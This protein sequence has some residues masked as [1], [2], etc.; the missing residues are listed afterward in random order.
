MFFNPQ[1]LSYIVCYKNHGAVPKIHCQINHKKYIPIM[2]LSVLIIPLSNWLSTYVEPHNQ[3]SV[4]KT[5]VKS[6]SRLTSFF[7]SYWLVM[8]TSCPDKTY[9]IRYT[10]NT[11]YIWIESLSEPKANGNWGF[12]HKVDR[13]SLTQRCHHSAER[14]VPIATK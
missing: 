14:A 2:N 10:L 1:Y 11:R 9:T 8:S 6:F 7:C 5:V 4:L 13:H 12:F 3:K